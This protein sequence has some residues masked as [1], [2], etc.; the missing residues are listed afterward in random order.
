MKTYLFS[1]I[2]FLVLFAGCKPSN[3]P[4]DPDNPNVPGKPPIVTVDSL[5]VSITTI[6]F[7]ANKDASLVVVRTNK[8]WTATKTAEWI[9]LSASSGNKNTG[10][11]IGAAAN[12][13]FSRES[14]VTIKA[15]DKTHEIKI[16]QASASKISITVNAVKF[17]MILVEGGLFTMGSS[18]HPDFGVPHQVS[19][20]DYYLSETEVTNA[21][22]SAVK[23][24]LPYTD[25]TE[26][27]KPAWPVSETTWNGII[28]DFIPALNQATG[29]TFRLPTEAEWEYAALGGKKSNGYKYAG[30]NML[31]D[32][33]WYQANSGKQKKEV[34]GKLPNQLGLYDMSGNVNEWCND[35]FDTYYGFPIV[36]NVLTPPN[37]Q[38]NPTGP[39]TGIRKLVRGG[40]FENDELWGF[41]YC[42]VKFRSSIKPSGYD[43]QEGSN[44]TIFFMSKNTGFR[45]VISL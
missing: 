39:A 42:N 34:K 19:L 16:N 30:S 25:H 24:S 35:W 20:S 44:P 36:N 8:A 22:W 41:S 3:P 17:N 28:N 14:T 9:S 45:L 13:G 4:V 6:S 31:E 29:K 43:T 33:A 2:F 37:L 7:T 1:L 15:G 12:S 18:E 11:L 40:N 23:G 32:V 26:A 38:T 5:G 10:F 21:I 27:D